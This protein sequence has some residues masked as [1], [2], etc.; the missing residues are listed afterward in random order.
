LLV[1]VLRVDKVHLVETHVRIHNPP[2]A[3]RVHDVELVTVHKLLVVLL[4]NKLFESVLV[5]V[6]H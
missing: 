3:A 6:S 1:D 2:V 4:L 5:H